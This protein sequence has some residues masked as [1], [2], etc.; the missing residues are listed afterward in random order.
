MAA[1]EHKQLID[2][3]R[4]QLVDSVKKRYTKT[5]HLNLVLMQ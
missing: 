1:D 2:E 5:V 3:V 4:V